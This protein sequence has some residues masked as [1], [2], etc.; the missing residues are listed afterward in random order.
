MFFACPVGVAALV[1]AVQSVLFLFLR[2]V[3]CCRVLIQCS[4]CGGSRSRCSSLLSSVVRVLGL[5]WLG[6][7]FSDVCLLGVLG[8]AWLGLEGLLGLAR[9]PKTR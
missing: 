7:D 5:A 6:L 9:L 2:L 8:L 1:A 3:C 4:S